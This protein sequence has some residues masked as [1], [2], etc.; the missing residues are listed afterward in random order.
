MDV[1]RLEF[2]STT[3]TKSWSSRQNSYLFTNQ[4]PR[5]DHRELIELGMVAIPWSHTPSRLRTKD[6]DH[7][8]FFL[9]VV[10]DNRH[11]CPDSRKEVLAQTQD[12]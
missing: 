6:E 9:Q 2:Y 7:L 10:A 11:N 8:Q 1:V 12:P 5:D 3:A 4:L